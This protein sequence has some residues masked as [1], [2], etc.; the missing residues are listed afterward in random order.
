MRERFVAQGIKSMIMLP[1]MNEDEMTGFV[2]LENLN[3]NRKF[4]ISEIY[5]CKYFFSKKN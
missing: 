5:I 3:K 1:L 4:D 2:A